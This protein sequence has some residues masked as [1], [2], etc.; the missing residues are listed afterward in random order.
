MFFFAIFDKSRGYTVNVGRSGSAEIDFAAV[1]QNE[2]LYVQVTPQLLRNAAC[3]TPQH[4]A[5][6]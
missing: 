4:P 5:V 2:K 6:R 1:R 3:I